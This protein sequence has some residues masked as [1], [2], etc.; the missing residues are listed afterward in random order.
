[1]FTNKETSRQIQLYLVLAVG[2]LLPVLGSVM[3]F[4]GRRGLRSATPRGLL[5][6]VLYQVFGLLFLALA[7]RHQ[8][9]RF[10][11]I[12]FVFPMRIAEW[13]DSFALFFGA[14]FVGL[15]VGFAMLAVRVALGMGHGLPQ[16]FNSAALFGSHITLLAVLL[17]LVNPFHEELLVRAFLITEMG[18]LYRSTILAVIVSV[19]LQSSYHLYQGLFAAILHGSTFL[20]F[21]IYY[22]RTRRILPVIMAHLYMDV[23]A[24]M[25]Y[26][27]HL[28]KH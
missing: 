12:G 22:V 16:K 8:R 19:V 21:S 28:G 15:V 5:L 6:H 13:G 24:L 3:V 9:R 10:K 1:M 26:S 11:D 4:L 20:V 2:F 7:L 27:S 25:V 23:S 14:M 17:V 18:Q